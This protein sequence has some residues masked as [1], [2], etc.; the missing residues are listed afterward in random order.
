MS[1]LDFCEFFFSFVFHNA[2]LGH[3]Q[4]ESCHIQGVP[5]WN[6]SACSHCIIDMKYEVYFEAHGVLLN[7][8][9]N[10]SQSISTLTSC[11]ILIRPLSQPVIAVLISIPVMSFGR[12]HFHISKM[13]TR[14]SSREDCGSLWSCT[15]AFVRKFS[16]VFAFRDDFGL[17]VDLDQ[18]MHTLLTL[19]SLVWRAQA[20]FFISK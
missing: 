2:P 6:R 8:P 12:L 9:S 18:L 11:Q 4:Y 19:H 14:V 17:F 16:F 1:K 7:K 10:F 5:F 15:D 20:L 13:S 3:N